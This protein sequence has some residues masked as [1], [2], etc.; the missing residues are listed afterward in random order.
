MELNNETQYQFLEGLLTGSRVK[1]SNIVNKLI[2]NGISIIDI[3]ENIIKQTMYTVGELWEYNKISVA[4][5]HLSS[6]ICSAI[7]NEHYFFIISKQKK[8]KKVLMA[9]VENEHHEIGAKM[10]SDIFEMN[11]W[12]SYFLGAKT[13]TF[14]LISFAKTISPDIIAISLSIYFHLPELEKLIK[15]LR[16]EFSETPILVGGQAFRHGGKEIL[17][18]YKNIIYQPDLNSTD[19]FIKNL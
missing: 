18:N 16:Q 13:P 4:T 9:C 1:C 2:E 14:D 12:K 3:Y 10:I 17:M 5:E 6:A 7:L 8:D 15:A 19:L 11:G